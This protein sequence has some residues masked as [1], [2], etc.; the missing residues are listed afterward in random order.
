MPDIFEPL[1]LSTGGNVELMRRNY[2]SVRERVA[3][4]VGDDLE[5]SS[6]RCIPASNDAAF[7]RVGY[8]CLPW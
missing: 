8:R 3:A 1:E 7:G 4:L 6:P 2:L 5:I